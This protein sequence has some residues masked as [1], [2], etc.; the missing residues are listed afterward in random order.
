MA[1]RGRKPT[2]TALKQLEGNP[3]KRPLNENEPV[4]QKKAPTCPKWLEPEAKKEW[5]RLAK[6]MEAIGILT[7]V[8]MAAFA[9]YCQ[10]FAR[11]KEAEEFI[12][13][14]GT[15]VKTPSGYYQQLPQVSI[16]QTYLKI[17]NRFAEQFGLTPASRSRIIAVDSGKNSDDEMESILNGGD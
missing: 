2:P 9:G 10:A 17:M 4:P 15:I 11:W 13:Q 14:H 6:Q 16:A 5:R 3:G 8:D 12:S 7:E 1:T